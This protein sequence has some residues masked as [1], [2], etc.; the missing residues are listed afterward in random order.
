MRIRSLGLRLII[1][2]TAVGLVVAGCSADSNGVTAGSGAIGTTVDI[3]PHDVSELRQGGNLRLQITGFPETFNSL[4]VDADG[5][6]SEVVG[7]TLPGTINSTASGELPIDRNYY[8]DI[9]LTGTE[10]QQ[11]TYTINPKAV[12]TDGTPI[13]WEDLASQANALSGRDNAFLVGATQGYSRV[14]KVE[15]GVDDRQAIVTMAKHYA[16]WQGMFNPLYPKASTATPQ[17]F[18]DLDRNGLHASAGPFVI[19]SI[20]RAQQR[21]VLG[22]NPKWWGD[23][24]VLDTVTYSV[25]DSSA[26]LSALQNNEL[27]SASI[28]GIDEVTTASGSPGLVVRRAPSLN[29]THM[30]F[31]GAPGSILEDPR[32]RVAVS[33]GI[34]R[35]GIAT[36]LLN[37]VVQDPKPLDNHLY[38]NGQKGYQNNAQ[39]V[40]YDPDQAAKELDELGWKLNGDV[41]EKDGRKLVIRNVMFQAETWNQVAQIAQQNLAAIGV[42]LDIQTYP[43][44]GLFTQVID[45]GNFDIANFVWSKSIFPLGALPQIYY[46]DPNNLQGNK[47]RIGSPELNAL[48]EEII[49]ELDPDKAIEMANEADKMIFA[50]GFSLPLYQSAG[51]IAQR[52]DLANWGAF[53]LQSADFTKVGF[54]K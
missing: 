11:I 21:I 27:D 12:W 34:D 3:N 4:H 14:A 16:E 49:S 33:K 51:T 40:A 17:A 18:N 36:A 15:R 20:D 44:N 53:G 54:L 9:Q 45:P 1:R 41:R 48:I 6:A 29:F 26:R 42:K 13:T 22:R 5:D 7:W 28:S 35:Q 19:T 25:L 50:E 52:A 39:S 2:A 24:P 10:P 43:G 32:L 30:T 46:Y 47:G 8:T 23:T 38:L 37:G 31:N